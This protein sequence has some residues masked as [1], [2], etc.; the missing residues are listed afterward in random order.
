MS[1]TPQRR[2]WLLAALVLPAVNVAA[3][4]VFLFGGGDGS[5]IIPVVCFAAEFALLGW[6]L[7]RDGLAGGRLAAWLAAGTASTV[8]A[9]FG[10]AW[11]AFL[12]WMAIVSAGCPAGGYECAF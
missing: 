1:F 7:A 10:Y 6:L 8:A 9:T 12:A 11:V 2:F 3:I 5:P 4:A